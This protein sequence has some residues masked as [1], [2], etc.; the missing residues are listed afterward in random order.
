M[1]YN[2]LA[3]GWAVRIKVDKNVRLRLPYFVLVEL[4]K[5]KEETGLTIS[6]LIRLMIQEM[7]RNPA[8]LNAILE[9]Y[10]LYNQRKKRRKD[11]DPQTK[12]RKDWFQW[13][14]WERV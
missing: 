2:P 1:N 7:L 8:Q 12:T 5:L 4:Y 11:T 13:E 14:E 6:A 9:P 10:K 3:A